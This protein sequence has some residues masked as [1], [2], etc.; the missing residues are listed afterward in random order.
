MKVH[1]ALQPDNVTPD[2]S[3]PPGKAL[4][5][6]IELAR[7]HLGEGAAPE[8][9]REGE[10][11]LVHGLKE[12]GVGL[13]HNLSERVEE[14]LLVLAVS[15]EGVSLAEGERPLH[16]MALLLS[17]IRESGTHL[18]LMSRLIALLH[19]PHL[20]ADLLAARSPEEMVRAVRRQEEAGPENYWV[21]SREE[22]LAELGTTEAGLSR[23]E[24]ARRLA[25]TGPNTIER[26]KRV[27]LPRRFAANLVNL[28]ALLLWAA[29]ALAWVA[30]LPE[31]ALAIPLVIIINA[32]FSFLQE[33]KAERAVEALESL[34]PP[35]AKVMRGG[36]LQEIEATGLVPGD[37]VVLEAGDHISADCRLIEARDFRV[38]N[39]VLTGESRPAYKFD[40]PVED[41]TRFLWTE[42]PNLIFAGTSALSGAARAVVI[43]TGMNT[44]LGHIAAL[45]QAVP[46][47]P[48]PLQRQVM[49]MTRF[50]AAAAF[51][52][53]ALFFFIGVA[54]GKLTAAASLIFAIG[55]LVAFVPE[56]LLPTL[57]LSLAIGVQRMAA[58]NALVKRLSSVETLGAATIIC[59]DKTGTLTTNEVMV[60]RLWIEGGELTVTG[61][62]YQPEGELLRGGN[63]VGEK[64]RASP[65]M[66]LISRCGAL[67]STT[68][69]L[70]PEE[71][72][73]WRVQGDPTEAA[74]LTLSAKLGRDYKIIR[75]AHPQRKLFPFESV[76]KRMA[77][78]NA[79][80]D[81]KLYCWVKG[82]PETVLARCTHL[83]CRDGTR[84]PLSERERAVIAT[85]YNDFA[86]HGLR[87]LALAGKEV[88]TADI[89]QERAESGLTL[90]AVTGMIDP[91]RPE[92]PEAIARCHRA[93]IR[94]I[95]ITGDYGPTA[96]A[97]AAQ[98]G[99]RLDR[100]FRVVTSGV[101]ATLSDIRL[102]ALLKHGEA[103]FARSSPE[104]KL[105]IVRVLREMGE[106]V[107]VT[108]DGVNDAPALKQAD[109]GVAMGQRGTEV[110]R[111]AAAMVLADDNFASIVAAVEEGRSVYANIKKFITYIF[112]SNIPE[113]VPFILFVLLGIP[114]PL[115][116]M[117]ILAIDLGTDL[118]PALALGAEPPE[119]GTMSRPP[120][121]PQARLIDLHLL[122]RSTYT[123]IMLTVA[124]MAAYYFAYLSAGWRPGLPMA[125]EGPVYA[126]ATTMCW[127]GIVAAQAG[128]ALARRT[129]RE[130]I[131]AV[132]LFTNRLI[133][134]GL[135]SMV[136]VVFLLSYV[137]FLQRLFGTAPLSATDLAFL[138][139]FPPL[140]LAAEEL[141][142]LWLRRRPPRRRA[143]R[144]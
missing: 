122:W 3:A 74:L 132:G 54:T 143:R 22:V 71:G 28:F 40:E 69:L 142:K 121:S 140:M 118:L 92:V 20:Q 137:P 17:P 45:T 48:S 62:G 130:S 34:L 6:L 128:N 13:F 120:R 75:A 39:S 42:M 14:P 95:M 27:S 44:Q 49:S 46:E 64:E 60:Q 23:E 26:R 30:R 81:G 129:E 76:R 67:C 8:G 19:S 58:K 12:D 65:L 110:S 53:G 84:R 51:S 73:P 136:V 114:L 139:I 2:F 7:R 111:E 35:R 103:V 9:F 32:V 100:R 21:L 115:Q 91:P 127:A 33:Y 37:I 133:W 113:A 29:T 52:I 85:A 43:A 86:S 83:A 50:V 93:G 41:G 105:R 99:L 82:A 47:E 101:L 4:E 124:A 119:P 77:T 135:A 96:R 117:Q 87:V 31:L 123:G 10:L 125:A 131:L 25:E 57:S 90:L 144:P 102:K 38:D 24:A 5:G 134:V 141:L 72:R 98:I 89:G 126:H 108:G 15:K 109:I 78:V 36:G 55:L 97:I 16:V 18:Q 61:A 56:G 112:A 63:P 88:E 104:D 68:L 107:A 66:E 106:V 1:E 116:V 94:V 70:P 80:P 11:N 138:L 59:T 79:A